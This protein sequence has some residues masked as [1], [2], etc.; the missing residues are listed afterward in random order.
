MPLVLSFPQPLYPLASMQLHSYVPPPPPHSHVPASLSL[1]LYTPQLLCLPWPLQ[2]LNFCLHAFWAPCYLASLSLCLSATMALVL[3]D[4]M[5]LSLYILCLSAF[6]PHTLCPLAFLS[7]YLNGSETF[8]LLNLSNSSAS[9]P[10]G[11]F[12]SVLL[13]PYVP[14]PLCPSTSMALTL[15]GPLGLCSMQLGPYVPGASVP[16]SLCLS[17]SPTFGLLEPSASLSLYLYD[18]QAPEPLCLY[19]A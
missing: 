18:P 15:S 17:D 8:W 14:W 10:T 6:L 12:V 3:S 7:I 4:F 19:A 13:S 2:P 16:L 9:M 1:W 11:F 5:Q